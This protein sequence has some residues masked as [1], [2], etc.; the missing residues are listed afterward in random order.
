VEVA[1]GRGEKLNELSHKRGLFEEVVEVTKGDEGL[2]GVFQ[3]VDDLFLDFRF[4][5]L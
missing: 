5:Q 3:D 1:E 2:V 4:L